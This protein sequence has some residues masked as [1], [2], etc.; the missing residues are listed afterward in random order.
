M[1][2]KLKILVGFEESQAV[3]IAFRN[4][5]HEA[6]SSDL[7]SCS[8]G[9]PEWHLKGNVFD[10]ID[11]KKWDLGIFFP[12]CTHLASSGAAHFEK[13]RKD[14][15]QQK[16]IELFMKVVNIPIKRIA[17]E[18]PVGIMSSVY[19]KPD[20]IIEPYFFGDPTT[21]KTC[22]WL[23]NLH[24]LFHAKEKDLFNDKI[25]HVEKGGVVE[26]SS[27]NKMSNWYASTGNLPHSERSKARSKTF[28]G[29]AKAMAEQWSNINF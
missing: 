4:L 28:P 17:I 6:F 9:F 29:I 10:F 25:T 24:P 27:G 2:K 22:L 5:G 26:F 19:R 3:T 15:R 1:K 23:K 20:Q 21:K 16:A 11:F 13:K 7:Q 8:G 14:G 18:N 12:P